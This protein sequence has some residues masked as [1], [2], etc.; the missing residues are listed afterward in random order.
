MFEYVNLSYLDTI[1]KGDENF[2]KEMIRIF[3]KQ[4][5]DFLSNMRKYLSGKEKEKLMKEAHTAKSSALIFMMEDAGMKLKQIKQL[6]E[7]DQTEKI[8]TLIDQVE[9]ALMGASQELEGYLQQ[10]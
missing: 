1:S 8:P 6:A 2:Q 5:P 9:T 4:I 3:L 7:T 10:E